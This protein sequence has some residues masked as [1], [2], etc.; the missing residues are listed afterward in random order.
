MT[1][2]QIDLWVDDAAEL[3]IKKAQCLPGKLMPEHV[4]AMILFLGA[5]DSVMC[6][7]QEFIVD[8]GWV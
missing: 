4:A 2:R 1:Q 8:A 7:G 3:E 6:T 5:D